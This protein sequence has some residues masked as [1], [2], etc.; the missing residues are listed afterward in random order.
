M[1]RPRHAG[2]RAQQRQRQQ[3]KPSMLGV[4]VLVL[5][6]CVGAPAV[7]VADESELPHVPDLELYRLGPFFASQHPTRWPMML[8]QLAQQLAITP[9][10]A[11]DLLVEYA[12]NHVGEVELPPNSKLDLDGL[13]AA[14]E[15]GAGGE[16]AAVTMGDQQ[17]WAWFVHAVAGMPR[18]HLLAF[19]DLLV[20]EG[21]RMLAAMH[22]VDP[23]KINLHFGGGDD[24][25][26]YRPLGEADP[27]AAADEE[28]RWLDAGGDE[29]ASTVVGWE[30]EHEVASR[31]DGADPSA[32]AVASGGANESPLSP[33][34]VYKQAVAALVRGT[35]STAARDLLLRAARMEHDTALLDLVEWMWFAPGGAMEEAGGGAAPTD[36]N[37]PDSQTTAGDGSSKGGDEGVFATAS[38][39]VGVTSKASAHLSEEEY[40]AVWPEVWLL[41]RQAAARGQEEAQLCVLL[42]LCFDACACACVQLCTTVI[43]A[44][45]LR[46]CRRYGEQLRGCCLLGGVQPSLP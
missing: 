43:P 25:G 19:A 15:L 9:V 44:V 35:N 33:E 6:A 7:V 11:E 3:L 10:S 27:V 18:Q 30:E 20:D 26:A 1:L 4:A 32:D 45:S 8:S 28:Q 37:T 23:S 41:L 2:P 21:T 34:D 12:A 17:E 14:F 42:L 29:E 31:S 5:V 13:D 36:G 40:A 24:E 39:L 22:G 46:C 38:K 16:A